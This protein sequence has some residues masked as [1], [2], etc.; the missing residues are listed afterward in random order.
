MTV[1]LTVAEVTQ[2]ANTIKEVGFSES[3]IMTLG[4]YIALLTVYTYQFTLH[5][6]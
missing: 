6:F 5:P 2:A 1:T 4:S 3:Q